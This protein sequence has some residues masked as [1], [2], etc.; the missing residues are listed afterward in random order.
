MQNNTVLGCVDGSEL[1]CAV[2]EYAAWIAQT[3]GKPLKFIH[4]VEH[5]SKPAPTDLSGNIGLGARD[6]L[7]ESLTE[8]EREESKTLLAKGKAAL[9]AARTCAAKMGVEAQLSQRHGPPYENLIELQDQ[10]RVLVLGLRGEESHKIGGQIE[11]VIRSLHKP[12]F[13]VSQA[14]TQPKKAMLAYDGSAAS[15]KALE[16]MATAPLF[17][18]LDCHV[19][20][21]SS[22]KADSQKLLDRA[23]EVLKAGGI[24][25]V[26]ATV[27]GDAIGGLLSYQ[28]AHDIDFTVMGA[29]S[30][31]RFRDALLGSFTAKMIA[32]TQKPLLLLR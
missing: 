29:F 27:E 2:A 18:Q 1:S 23:G 4:A 32:Q 11:E 16:M 15:E 14:F 10:M 19:V 17:K 31:N 26:L 6:E 13:L 25:A 12:I 20:H 21:A 7:L 8:E 24:D 22:A 9:E 5:H 28:N 3:I 30:H